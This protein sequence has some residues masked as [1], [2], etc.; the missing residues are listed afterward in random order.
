MWR[1]YT[2]I[3]V[4]PSVIK[5]NIQPPWKSDHTLQI[6]S[7]PVLGGTK[8]R[9]LLGLVLKIGSGPTICY[10]TKFKILLVVFQTH[11]AYIQ[12]QFKNSYTFKEAFC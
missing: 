3:W 10:K 6:V 8:L 5:H 7:I 1:T 9:R 11:L 4:V 12:E 2:S